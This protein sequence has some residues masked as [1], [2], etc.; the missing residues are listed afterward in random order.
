MR[1][2]ATTTQ[3]ARQL[4]SWLYAVRREIDLLA[5]MHAYNPAANPLLGRRRRRGRIA[6]INPWH[7]SAPDT[8]YIHT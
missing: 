2:S 3:L 8:I 6:G 4:D 5:T 7:R 1:R